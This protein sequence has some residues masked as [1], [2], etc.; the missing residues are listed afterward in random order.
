MHNFKSKFTGSHGEVN[1]TISI[2]KILFKCIIKENII[3]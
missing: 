2:I 1:I 3:F